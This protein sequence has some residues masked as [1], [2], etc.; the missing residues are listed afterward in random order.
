MSIALFCTLIA[1]LGVTFILA[2]A[3]YNR[4]QKIS[5]SPFLVCVAFLVSLRFWG[6]IKNHLDDR[7]FSH[8][9]NEYISFVDEIKSGRIQAGNSFQTID[10]NQIGRLPGRTKG[11]RAATCEQSLTE[12]KNRTHSQ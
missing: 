11:V 6:P 8:S 7:L 4:F 1:T 3:N 2:V 10:L 12:P 9:M 5:A